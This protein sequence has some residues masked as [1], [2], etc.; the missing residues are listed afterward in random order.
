MNIFLI[1]IHLLI[2][3]YIGPTVPQEKNDSVYFLETK[4]F[5]IKLHQESTPLLID[6]GELKDYR[7]ERINGAIAAPTQEDLL[8][9][10]DTLDREQPVFIYCKYISRSITALKLLKNMNFT[11][12]Y[13][14]E[15]GI[16][17]WKNEGL[18]T[19]KTPVKENK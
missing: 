3:S 12:I 8:S 6:V 19:D 1:I 18:E 4:E 9:L 5:Y 2:I 11:N 17:G 10:T 13:I 7:N 16:I 14:L 15:N